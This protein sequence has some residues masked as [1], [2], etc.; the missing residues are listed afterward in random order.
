[1]PESTPNSRPHPRLPLGRVTATR[2]AIALLQRAG[3]SFVALLARHA[4]GDWGDID[5]EDAAANEDSLL[6]GLRVLSAYKLQISYPDSPR[7]L[8]ETIWVVTEADRSATV[9][10]LPEEY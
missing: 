6:R 3:V 10:L 1:M 2:G 7:T 9:F 4:R 5:A 8:E